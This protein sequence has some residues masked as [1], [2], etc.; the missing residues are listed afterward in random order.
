MSICRSCGFFEK[1]L[2]Y[3]HL[4]IN[5]DGLEFDTNSGNAS[6]SVYN[7]LAVYDSDAEDKLSPLGKKIRSLKWK[8]YSITHASTNQKIE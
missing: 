3:K 8:F 5:S 2:L 7:Q 1:D 6:F 4:D